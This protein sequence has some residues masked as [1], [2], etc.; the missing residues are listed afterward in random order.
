MCVY[1]CN[2]A[3]YR[4]DFSNPSC[5]SLLYRVQILFDS[6]GHAGDQVYMVVHTATH[7]TLHQRLH[8]WLLGARVKKILGLVVAVHCAS[9]ET[10]LRSKEGRTQGLGHVDAAGEQDLPVD[11]F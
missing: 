5:F 10:V 8:G 3:V 1:V 7:T 9:G 11:F 4:T 6:S 2:E